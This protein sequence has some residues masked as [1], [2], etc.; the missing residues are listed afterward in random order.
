MKHQL[1]FTILLVVTTFCYQAI[2]KANPFNGTVSPLIDTLNVADFSAIANDTKEDSQAFQT[3]ID[4]AARL[5]L[6]L[7]IPAGKFYIK[8]VELRNYIT[9]IGEGE[10]TVLRKIF[11]GEFALGCNFSYFTPRSDPTGAFNVKNITITNIAFEGTSTTDGFFQY[12][13]LLNLNGVDNVKVIGCWFKG[14]N[15]DGVYVGSDVG[16]ERHSSNIIISQ[17]LFDGYNKENRNGISVI[18]GRN[19]TIE[20]NCFFNCSRSDMPGAID[21]E[22]DA[23][24]YHRVSDI[25]IAGN[26]F[27]NIGGNVE[28][29]LLVVPLVQ[30]KLNL[31]VQNIIINKNHIFD[32]ANGIALYQNNIATANTV[33]HNIFITENLVKNSSGYPLVMYGMGS[34]TISNNIFDRFNVNV[35]IGVPDKPFQC[36]NVLFKNFLVQRNK[37]NG[38]AVALG[39]VDGY[40]SRN[41]TFEDIGMTDGKYGIILLGETKGES[42]NVQSI[43]DIV[44]GNTTTAFSQ[45]NP[46]HDTQ[47]QLNEFVPSVAGKAY[48]NWFPFKN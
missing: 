17:C 24:A 27:K 21:V 14:F 2:G 46:G 7:L 33:S 30:S 48:K 42:S 39:R 18:D 36:Y 34:V 26:Y 9:L 29:I 15:G 11:S 13:H 3:A 6:P 22:P 20:N 31:A 44:T 10:A 41:N 43:N 38:A 32:V 35:I 8:D 28:T 1:I 19:I 37:V 23:S 47:K 25:I 40:F 16:V 45:I 5:R 4:A 12:R